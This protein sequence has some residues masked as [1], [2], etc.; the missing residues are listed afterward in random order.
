MKKHTAPDGTKIYTPR[1][2][3]SPSGQTNIITDPAITHGE[4]TAV[5]D[6]N[7]ALGKQWVDENEL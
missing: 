5:N 1:K 7:I 6:E 4:Y 2:K 3:P